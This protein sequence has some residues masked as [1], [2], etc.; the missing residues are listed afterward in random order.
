MV[1]RKFILDLKPD[2]S[3]KW[4]EVVGSERHEVEAYKRIADQCETMMC[5][6][7]NNQDK[8]EAYQYVLRLCKNY[9]NLW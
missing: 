9:G 6:Y 2:G 3:V 5:L 1:M 7:Q 4:A 8:F